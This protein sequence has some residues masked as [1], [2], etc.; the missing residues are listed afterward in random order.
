MPVPT[1]VGRC[2]MLGTGWL[3]AIM[4][5]LGT[6]PGSS[7]GAVCALNHGAISLSPINQMLMSNL[8]L[9]LYSPCASV[10]PGLTVMTLV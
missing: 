5:M 10:T 2:W 6:E 3:R 8:V 9:E 7:V 1:E 4:W